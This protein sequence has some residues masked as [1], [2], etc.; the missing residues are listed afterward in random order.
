MLS[1]RSLKKTITALLVT[2]FV[3]VL[4]T[5]VMA[6]AADARTSS[7]RPDLTGNYDT[8]TLTP[9]SRP[10]AFGD[11]LYLTQEEADKIAET[12]R[13][14]IESRSQNSDPDREAPPEG[15]DGSTGASGNVHVWA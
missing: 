13:T 11:N 2:G 3:L 10:A 5:V 7:G 1:P 14:V 15:G 6:E 9:L 12:E 4:P 8:A